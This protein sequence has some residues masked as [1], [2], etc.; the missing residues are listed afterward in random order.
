MMKGLLLTF[1]TLFFF[2]FATPLVLA[3]P[4]N[5]DS[6]GCHTCRTNC[7]SWGLSYGEYHCHNSKGLTQPSS[8]INSHWGDNGTGYTTPS[9]LYSPSI[10]DN[11]YSTTCPSHSR[12]IQC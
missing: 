12:Y 3:H 4:G 7:S 10:F 8:P 5:T 1:A 6:S 9:S 11:T 2:L